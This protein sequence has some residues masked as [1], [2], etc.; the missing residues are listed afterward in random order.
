MGSVNPAKG[1]YFDR[2]ELPERFRRMPMEAWEIE[3]ID[4]G[5]ASLWN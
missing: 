5:G 2:S 1:E 4:S 3:A